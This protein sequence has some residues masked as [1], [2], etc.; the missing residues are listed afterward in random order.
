NPASGRNASISI[1]GH[2]RSA[3]LRL[4]H[5]RPE[6]ADAEGL[7]VP[8]YPQLTIKDG[9]AVGDFDQ[10]RNKQKQRTKQHQA[11]SR[12]G[13]IVEAFHASALAFPRRLEGPGPI[14]L[15]ATG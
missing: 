1:A 5:H 7:S 12:K 3:S 11:A 14:R 9:A 4:R 2:Q 13:R 8:A 10:H 6:F 15:S